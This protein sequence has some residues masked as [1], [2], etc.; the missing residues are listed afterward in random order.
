MDELWPQLRVY[1]EHK[2]Q[3]YLFDGPHYVTDNTVDTLRK[4]LAAPD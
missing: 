1:K 3:V 4:H 2:Y